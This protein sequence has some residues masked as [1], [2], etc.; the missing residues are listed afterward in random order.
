MISGTMHGPRSRGFTMVEILVAL[1]I[2]I[3]SMA[4]VLQTFSASEST[5]RTTTGGDDAQVAGALSLF[6]L[7]RDMAQAGYG[8]SST[9]ILGCQLKLN[10]TGG[11][12]TLTVAPVMINPPTSLIP[13]GDANTDTL[14]IMYG[15]STGAAEGDMITSQAATNKYVMQSPTG[16]AVNDYVTVVHV[17]PQTANLTPLCT[18]VS[19][20]DKITAIP[21]GTSSTVTVGTGVAGLAASTYT[22][23]DLG[24]SPVIVGYAVRNAALTSC[25]Y[26]AADCSNTD[27]WTEVSSNIVSMRAVYGHNHGSSGM[28]ASTWDQTTPSGTNTTCSWADTA[29]VAIGLVARNTTAVNSGA[30]NSNNGTVAASSNVTTTA[31]VWREAVWSTGSLTWGG[32]TATNI[33]MDLSSNVGIPASSG[34]TWQNYRYRLYSTVVPLRNITAMGK[35]SGC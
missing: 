24:Q 19:I 28:S 31:P 9:G 5:K 20:L 3:I 18:T 26:I 29:A 21:T 2:G 16:W 14:L 12:K 6:D 22:L 35:V 13:A 30:I 27:N 32:T 25:N 33:P 17:P 10:S 4:V 34:Y 11:N 15:N 1:V 7:E 23:Y 8:I